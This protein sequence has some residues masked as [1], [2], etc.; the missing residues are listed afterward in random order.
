M[1]LNSVSLIGR[2][3]ADPE[4]TTFT[5]EGETKSVATFRV[6]VN[7]NKK[8]ADAFFFDA[9]A[10]GQQGGFLAQY[11]SKGSLV[12]VSG[13]LTQESWKNKES[14]NRSKVVV[15]ASHVQL[16]DGRSDNADG[17]DPVVQVANGHTESAQSEHLNTAAQ[18]VW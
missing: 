18:P 11:A 6:A 2:L 10:F 5:R 12:A 9:K 13:R 1:S 17:G 14:E 4:V 3:T 8:D 16:L 7:Q 15:V